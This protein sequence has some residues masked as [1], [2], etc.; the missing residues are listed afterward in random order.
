MIPTSLYIHVPW[1]IR[2]CPYCDFNSHKS[3]QDLPE[4]QYI[5]ALINDL[6]E[7]LIDCPQ[8]QIISIFIGGGT[9]S[10]L[11]ASAYAHLLEEIGKLLP[12]AKDIEITLEANPGTVEQQRFRGYRKA[13]IN[14]LSLG[15]QSFN[16]EHLKKL[17]RIHDDKQAH[18]AIETARQAGFENIN[19]DLMHGL[20]GQTIGQGLADLRQA[21]QYEPEHLSWY[22]L[23][24][25]PNTVFYKQRPT[26]PE[27]DEIAIMEEQG[28]ALLHESAY[29]R[30][31]ISA[32]SRENKTSRHNLNYWLFGD[33][34]GI[35]AGAHGKLT[36]ELATPTIIRSNKYRQPSDYLN[37]DKPFCASR[38]II[39]PDSLLFEF[40]LNTTRL[41]QAIPL[42]LFT[43][44]TGLPTNLLLNKLRRACELN[45]V[46]LEE[47]FWQVSALGRQFTNNLQEL[48]LP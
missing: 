34:F 2:K 35:G 29:T 15:I 18:F 26:L 30:Y 25:E 3:P 17:G 6:K 14:R 37:Q 41:E 5:Q 27:D 8:R 12:L 24:L 46:T 10:L 19:L 7:D 40:C 31:E 21:L 20:P 9:P 44:R 43:E 28:F 4:Q 11:S 38:E 23:T 33:Y 42:E 45:L 32:F 36:R 13:G 39:D 16:P 48:F 22:Q 1:C 47:K